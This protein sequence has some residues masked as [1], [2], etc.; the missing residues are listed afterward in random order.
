MFFRQNKY[1]MLILL[2]YIDGAIL[3]RNLVSSI[4]TLISHLSKIFHMKNLGDLHYFLGVQVAQ[5]DDTLTLPQSQYCI[6]LLQHFSFEGANPI[7]TPL[8]PNVH[9]SMYES[10]LLSNPTLYKKIVGTLQY[11]T[12]TRPNVAYVVNFVSYFMQAPCAPHLTTITRIFKYLKG[13]INLYLNF[14][15]APFL[16]RV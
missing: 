2:I 10:S 14:T 9:L 16:G 7:S 5:E 12:L 15:R 6:S 4:N 11:H 3:T 8:A 1:E 13:N